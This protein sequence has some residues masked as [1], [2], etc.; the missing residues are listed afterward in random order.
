M[1]HL[2]SATDGEQRENLQNLAAGCVLHE[3]LGAPVCNPT[4]VR[5]LD[6][7]GTQ[8]VTHLLHRMWMEGSWVQIQGLG[9]ESLT[10]CK[11]SGAVSKEN[12]ATITHLSCVKT[13]FSQS[14]QSPI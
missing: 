14:T 12:K 6:D 11:G 1:I 10:F 8:N 3:I 5:G 2:T 7:A 13:K 9:T 4:V